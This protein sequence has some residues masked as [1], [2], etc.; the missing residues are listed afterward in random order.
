MAEKNIYYQLAQY[1]RYQ[2]PKIIYKF[3]TGADMRLT[4]G[5]AV[6]QKRLNPT[7]GF[8]DL[9]IFARRG[10]HSGLFIEI[11]KE[12]KSPLKRDGTL[13]KDIHLHEQDKMHIRLRKEG[14]TGGF[15]V[16]FDECQQMI[17]SYL[18]L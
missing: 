12:G 16:G 7:R 18:K 11:K 5:Q 9:I 10:I 14:Y 3:D 15:G 2:Y 13:K 8:P 1:M 17:D 4:I 6:K